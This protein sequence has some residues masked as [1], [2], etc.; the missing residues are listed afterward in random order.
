MSR[1]A[2]AGWHCYSKLILPP[3]CA[4]VMLSE[5]VGDRLDNLLPG[6]ELADRFHSVK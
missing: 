2:T 5:A 4:L 3:M 6:K 1:R